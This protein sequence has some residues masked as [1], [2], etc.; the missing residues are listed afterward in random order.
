MANSHSAAGA[1]IWLNDIFSG[2]EGVDLADSGIRFHACVDPSDFDRSR[3]LVFIP[4]LSENEFTLMEYCSLSSVPLFSFTRKGP[5]LLTV[6]KSNRF[7][8]NV[9]I[10]LPAEPEGNWNVKRIARFPA[11]K[12]YTVRLSETKSCPKIKLGFEMPNSAASGMLISRCNVRATVHY[13]TLG[14]YA[15]VIA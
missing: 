3:K 5:E 10:L 13:L 12:E 11:E 2:K 8:R 1:T 4:P 7:T 14:M 15:G 9:N 6:I